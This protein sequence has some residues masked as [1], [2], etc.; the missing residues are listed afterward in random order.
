MK[1]RIGDMIV[2]TNA[3]KTHLSGFQGR[4]FIITRIGEDRVYA[5][6]ID[7]PNYAGAIV[8]ILND[9]FV[10]DEVSKSPLWQVLR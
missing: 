9:C 2:L 1:A 5:H 10:I 3:S 8:F 7:D 4:K 6:L